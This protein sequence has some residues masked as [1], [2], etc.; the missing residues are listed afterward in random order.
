MGNTYRQRKLS[1]TE[2]DLWR[3]GVRNTFEDK[4]G[5]EL[6]REDI[7]RSDNCKMTYLI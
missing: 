4:L 1:I 2:T 6:S 7:K 3:R 5:N